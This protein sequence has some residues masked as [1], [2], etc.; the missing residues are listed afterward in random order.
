[1]SGPPDSPTSGP[2]GGDPAAGPLRAAARE[3]VEIGVTIREA[4][5]HVTAALT[6]GALL[7]ALPRAPSAGSGPPGAAAGDHQRRG[8]GTRSPAARWAPLAAKSA[9]WRARR[10]WPYA[11]WPPRCGC[12]SPRSPST[13]PS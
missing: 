4:A 8:L 5:G 9:A 1:M 12:G 6:D 13:T 10:A 2:P 11:C 3:L 7:R